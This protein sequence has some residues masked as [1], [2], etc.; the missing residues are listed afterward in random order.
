MSDHDD[1][2][3]YG[4]PPKEHR[5]KKGTSGN[6]RGRPS[7]TKNMDSLINLELDQA[8]TLKEGGREIRL[9]KRQAIVKRLVN[10]AL[11]G[12]PRA[13]QYLVQYAREHG[14][15]DPF[16]VT[17]D[18]VSAFADAV[19]RHSRDAGYEGAAKGDKS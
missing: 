19:E 15:G 8:I 1:E 14:A 12:D 3:G 13:I 17:D 18:D 7:R 4:K 16:E 2:V 10:N 11:K 6:P 5:F 9:P